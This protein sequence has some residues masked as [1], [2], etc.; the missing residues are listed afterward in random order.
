MTLRDDLLARLNTVPNMGQMHG[1]ERYAS[2]QT[3]LANLYKSGDTLR[4]G[5]IRWLRGK[6]T[7]TWERY[8]TWE[9]VMLQ[10]W[11]DEQASQVEFDNRIDVLMAGFNRDTR[12]GDWYAVDEGAQGW[13]LLKNQPA[14]VAGV[15]CHHATLQILL[16]RT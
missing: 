14:L 13:Q 5:F 10:G 3:V 1:Y 16:M 6:N 9:L 2:N 8:Q 4:G 15:L 7:G 12:V 11:N